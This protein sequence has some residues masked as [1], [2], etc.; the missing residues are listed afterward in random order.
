[1]KRTQ[2]TLLTTVILSIAL[3]SVFA[4]DFGNNDSATN[5]VIPFAAEAENSGTEHFIEMEAVKMP[6]GMYAY[7]M[8][9]Y[10]LDLERDGEND[11]DLVA[12]G[13]FDTDPSIPG[14][15]LVF[16]EGD[17][18]HVKLTN[19]ACDDF[20]I[21]DA[22]ENENSL[23]GIHVHGVHYAITDDA[24]Y[25]RMNM[26]GNSAASC[27][28]TVDYTWQV[29]PGTEGTWPYHD[30]TFLQNEVGAEDIGLFGTI[31]VNP[32]DDMVGG[33]VDPET[34]MI[35]EVSVTEDILKK[36]LSFGWSPL[37]F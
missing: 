32:A 18:A 29:S 7:K 35:T 19:N 5:S 31:I 9:S 13:T 33:F 1:M 28:N 8:V 16:T 2:I 26:N 14:P 11:A 15:T 22:G 23:V 10:K 3:I 21:G 30:H 34:G 36:N 20:V 27:S 6:D 25:G 17:T 37:K 4:V 12:D 24:T